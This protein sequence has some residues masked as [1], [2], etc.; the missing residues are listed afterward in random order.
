MLL[1]KWNTKKREY[2]DYNIS[3]DWNVKCYS[4]DMDEVINCASCGK[5]IVYGKCYTSLE[6]HTQHRFGYAACD[7]CYR[8]EIA[9]KVW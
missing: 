4:E 1:Q 5:K 6:I 7:E 2:E 8:E 3:N 9:K